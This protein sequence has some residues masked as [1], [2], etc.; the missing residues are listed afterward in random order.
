MRISIEEISKIISE[1]NEFRIFTH[2]QPDGDAVASAVG[3]A[4]ILQS[5]GKKAE[6]KCC[7]KFP[8]KLMSLTEG[9]ENDELE[10]PILISVDN[11][12]IERLG[13]YSSEN[14]T[15]CIDHHDSNKC[16][17]ENTYL[18]ADAVSCS[19]IIYKI[20]RHM[21]VRISPKA[22]ELLFA[23]IITDSLCFQSSATNSEAFSVA[24]KM[25]QFIDTS[26]I[27]NQVFVNK[28]KNELMVE[29]K[30]LGS[31]EYYFDNS[32]VIGYLTNDTINLIGKNNTGGLSS[33]VMKPHGVVL[34]ITILE[35]T[36]GK[37]NV[38][39]RS[40]SELDVSVLAAAMGG[41]GHQTAAGTIIEADNV[42]TVID[43]VVD[44]AKEIYNF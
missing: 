27:I 9:F 26:D 24:S 38:T 12:S 33:L 35:K 17:V 20:F 37:Y 43:S 32:L 34:G 15:V 40:A 31:M 3:L 7:D 11:A 1:N 8:E 41:G 22:L 21:G 14:V 23:G 19:L 29:Q 28:S 36:P 4:M 16:Y 30:L 10:N 13:A 44:K 5:M 39:F 2:K 18:E 6:V 25:A 42:H